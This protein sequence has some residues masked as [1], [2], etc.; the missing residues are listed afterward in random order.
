MPL[1]FLLYIGVLISIASVLSLAWMFLAFYY[2]DRRWYY[3]PLAQATVFNT[4]LIGILLTAIGVLGLYIARI[5]DEV[6]GRPLF[7]VRATRN[8]PHRTAL[9]KAHEQGSIPPR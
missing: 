7:V 5:H 4:L 3:T 1:R 9:E 2:V 8:T 6:L